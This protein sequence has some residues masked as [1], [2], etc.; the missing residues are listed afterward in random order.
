MFREGDRMKKEIRIVEE[1]KGVW[2]VYRG[3]EWLI[4]F[5]DEKGKQQAQWFVQDYFGLAQVA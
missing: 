5:Y 1:G 3:A 2:V 4:K